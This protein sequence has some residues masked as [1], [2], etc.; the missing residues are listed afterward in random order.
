MILIKACFASSTLPQEDAALMAAS[1]LIIPDLNTNKSN[2][3]TTTTAAASSGAS[4]NNNNNSATDALARSNLLRLETSELLSEC[5]LHIHPT[6]DG[7]HVHYEAKW[8]TTVRSYL[9][10]VRGVLGGLSGASLSADV[11]LLPPAANLKSGSVKER[12]MEHLI[13]DKKDGEASMYRIPL[14]SDKFHKSQTATSNNTSWTFPF[15]GGK[16]LSLVPIGSFAH[17][18]NAGLANKHAN[19]GNVLPVLDVAVLI[20]NNNGT[21][22][23]EEEAFVGGKDY[24]NH[25]YTDVSMVLSTVLC[26]HVMIIFCFM[27]NTSFS[28][29]TCTDFLSILFCL[30][31]TKQI[32]EK[33][34][35]SRT[36]CQT[37][38]SK[39]TPSYNWR[40][41][42]NTNLW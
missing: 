41:T 3:T 14:L 39:E 5:Q 4:D 18:G 40:C 20:D 12:G 9:E 21:G 34:Y 42:F 37:T 36:H 38:F 6:G 32:T 31:K 7:S 23:S 17:L 35:P 2:K 15:H 28:Y 29:H 25:R 33:E 16:T 8:S 10:N 13:P 24:L 19:G 30:C 26:F 1:Q 11:A 22:G 27:P